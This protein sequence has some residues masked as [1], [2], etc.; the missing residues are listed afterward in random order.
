MYIDVFNTKIV[1]SQIKDWKNIWKMQTNTDDE[2][3]LKSIETY[4]HEEDG[5][6]FTYHLV[7]ILSIL[8]LD[9]GEILYSQLKLIPNVK[10]LF[11]EKIESLIKEFNIS[12]NE[13]LIQ[14]LMIEFEFP[15][16]E[17]EEVNINFEDFS[18]NN[19][20]IQSYLLSAGIVAECINSMR[21]FYMDRQVNKIGTTNWD[22]LKSCI[23]GIDPFKAGLE[24]SIKEYDKMKGSNL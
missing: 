18:E 23:Y 5:M 4:H 2:M 9:E 8:E 24:R 1:S 10:Y 7:L 12:E 21:G 16:L 6:N 14:D 19:P 11:S 15:I 17:K 22:L 13:L 20:E 3:I